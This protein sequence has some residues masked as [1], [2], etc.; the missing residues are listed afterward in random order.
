MRMRFQRFLTA[1]ILFCF[2]V[3]MLLGIRILTLQDKRHVYDFQ[4]KLHRGH[5]QLKKAQFFYSSANAEIATNTPLP[6]SVGDPIKVTTLDTP[7]K[8]A[9]ELKVSPTSNF[10]QSDNIKR[11]QKSTVIKGGEPLLNYNVHVFYYAWYGNPKFDNQ[12]Y[13]HWNHPYLPHWNEKENAKWPKGQHMPPDDIGSNFYPELGPYSSQDPQVIETHMEQIS[14]AGIGVIALSWYPP[15][16][17]DDNGMPQEFFLP[18]LLD[19]ADKHKVKVAFHIE[20]YK[21]RDPINLKDNVK[22]L[23]DTYGNHTAFYRQMRNGK[24]LPLF[25]IY[26]SYQIKPKDWAKIFKPGPSSLRNSHYDGIFIG[27]LVEQTHKKDLMQGGFDGFYTYFASDGFSYGSKIANWP[28]LMEFAKR[29]QLLFI[30]SVGPGYIDTQ[31]RPWNGRNTKDRH[32]GL[33]YQRMLKT[34]MSVRPEIISITSFNEWHEGTQIENAVP[35]MNGK[36]HY[37]DYSPNPP[38]FYLDLT[39]TFVRQFSKL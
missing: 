14:S 32:Y 5:K 19:V 37:L 38:D 3:G 4:N 25:Y 12:N 34:A 6:L 28:L 35:F 22:Y 13:I 16:M 2:V 36:F 26:D 21:G 31:V 17:A 23:I 33:Y 11:V 29:T 18:K 20:P 24:K 27:L 7:K 1:A 15:D 8:K 30:P 39:K 9:F 10:H